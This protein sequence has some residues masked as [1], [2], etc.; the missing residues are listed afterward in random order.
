MT[1]SDLIWAIRGIDEDLLLE[2]ERDPKKIYHRPLKI[3]L[4][5]AAMVLLLGGTVLGVYAGVHWSELMET[6]FQA[7][8]NDKALL[9]DYTQTVYASVEQDGFTFR[10]TQL[11]GDEHCM[12]AALEIQLP[13]ELSNITVDTEELLSV[14]EENGYTQ[15]DVAQRLDIGYD[16]K[17]LPEIIHTPVFPETH[18]AAVHLSKEDLLYAAEE[19]FDTYSEND[20]PYDWSFC[21]SDVLNH[22]F[23][24]EAIDKYSA[25]IGTGELLQMYDPEA[26]KLTSLIYMHSD[27]NLVG[28]PCTLV[29][30]ELFLEDLIATYSRPEDDSFELSLTPLLTE[31]VVLHFDA[32]YQ[33]EGQD[34]EIYQEDTLIGTMSLSPFTA[35]LDFPQPP[36]DPNRLPPNRIDYLQ[37]EELTV[38][39]TNGSTV[40]CHEKSSGFVETQFCFAMTDEIVDLEKIEKITLLDYTF[41]PI[42]N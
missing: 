11:M 32:T 12:V 23:L 14:A 26:N 8:E 30:S 3:L 27:L 24:K 34:Y 18:F 25:S 4:I 35:N 29:I 20:S 7:D 33:P 36:D 9:D 1:N 22:A 10:V 28:R 40:V 38:T 37:D 15:E 39:L 5:A 6:Y 16:Y 19:Q 21:V 2:T 31:P 17:E 13:E 41:K 42:N